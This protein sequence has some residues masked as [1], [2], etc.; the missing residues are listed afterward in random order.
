LPTVWCICSQIAFY[1]H[2]L[3]VKQTSLILN[4]S[5]SHGRSA[6]EFASLVMYTVHW[7]GK[8][9]KPALHEL[10][11]ICWAVLLSTLISSTKLKAVPMKAK[12]LD[13]TFLPLTLTSQDPIRSMGLLPKVQHALLFRVAVRINSL[14]SYT[15]GS[16]D[17]LAVQCADA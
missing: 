8:V 11:R 6:Y 16:Q 17:T 7:L 1:W 3:L 4:T 2:F 12:A 14:V 10:S 15:F 13:S 9:T 5:N